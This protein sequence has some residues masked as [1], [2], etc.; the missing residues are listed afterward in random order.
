MI[1]KGKALTQ[2]V[3]MTVLETFRT[4]NKAMGFIKYILL[5]A[6]LHPYHV[7]LLRSPHPVLACSIKSKHL[8]FCFSNCVS[9][10]FSF[11]L[12]L[13]EYGI[14]ACIL[15]GRTFCLLLFWF[16]LLS[17]QVL[18]TE[19]PLVLTIGCG[20]VLQSSSEIIEVW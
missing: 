4:Q 16:V 13:L 2:K 10:L 15:D 19:F 18:T 3:D 20:F 9:G 1:H 11:P 7:Q 12:L 6:H 8:S 17:L 14:C 5:F